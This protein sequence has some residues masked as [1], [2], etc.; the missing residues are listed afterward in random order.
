MRARRLTAS[1]FH[2]VSGAVGLPL[3]GVE[4]TMLAD[5]DYP[6]LTEKFAANGVISR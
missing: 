3:A 4:K 6:M 5:Y 1:G 2:P